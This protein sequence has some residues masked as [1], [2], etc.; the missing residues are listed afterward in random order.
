M[1]PLKT[2]KDDKYTILVLLTKNLYFTVPFDLPK[3]DRNPCE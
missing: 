3:Y 1:F 2:H